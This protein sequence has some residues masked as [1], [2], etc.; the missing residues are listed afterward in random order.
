VREG[1]RKGFKQLVSTIRS[2]P[3]CGC[4]A[5]TLVTAL[6]ATRRLE[7][8][9]EAAKLAL[10]FEKSPGLR[11]VGVVGGV[12]GRGEACDDDGCDAAHE[13]TCEW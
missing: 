11:W 3:G 2:G 1:V 5:R 4:Y 8:A 10:E 12:C 6:I 7:E 9:Q 13:G